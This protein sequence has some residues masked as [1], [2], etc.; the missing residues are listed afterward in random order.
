MGA[1]VVGGIIEETVCVQH[2]RRKTILRGFSVKLFKC[3]GKFK[4]KIVLI[5]DYKINYNCPFYHLITV[6]CINN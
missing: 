1:T 2:Y 4:L 6:K 3:F 5:Y